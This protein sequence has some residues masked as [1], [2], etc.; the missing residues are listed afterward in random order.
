MIF[1]IF[2]YI[3]ITIFKM[4]QRLTKYF[5]PKQPIKIQTK[6]TEFFDKK[7]EINNYDNFCIICNKNLGFQNPRQLCGKTFCFSEI[8]FKAKI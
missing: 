4:E 5:Y 3:K 8:N 7:K 6:I 1:I 2:H